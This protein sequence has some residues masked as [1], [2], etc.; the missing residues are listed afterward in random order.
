[1]GKYGVFRG[2]TVERK[3]EGGILV[4]I[5]RN[6]TG[7]RDVG[8]APAGVSPYGALDMAGNV[9]EW[10]DGWGIGVNGLRGRVA[11]GSSW[12]D[13]RR[14]VRC[15]DAHVYSIVRNQLNPSDVREPFTGFRVA[16]DAN[17]LPRPN[18]LERYRRKQ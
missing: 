9:R 14:D 10:V 3:L 2:Y 11:R 1:M 13:Y 15:M 17:A 6:A 5:Q 18:G 8:S 7:T 16:I 12:Q 4:K